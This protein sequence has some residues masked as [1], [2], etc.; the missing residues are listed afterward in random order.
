MLPLQKP[1]M[2][3]NIAVARLL[4]TGLV[5]FPG[6]KYAEMAVVLGSL[7][8]LAILH[9][10][11]HWQTSG[12]GFYGDHL[13]FE[14]IYGVADGDIDRVAEKMV[15]LGNPILVG[16]SKH[17]INLSSFLRTLKEHSTS[18]DF[19]RRS[20]EAELLFVELVETAMDRLKGA[21]LLTRGLEQLLGD[22][23]DKHEGVIYLLKQRVKS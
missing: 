8:A 2:T 16:F 18:D 14:R 10:T 12:P 9:Q 5:M 15:G 20:L 23:A 1:E 7:R 22:V 6:E 11:H 17:V 3:E 19:A 13:L 21:G 4:E